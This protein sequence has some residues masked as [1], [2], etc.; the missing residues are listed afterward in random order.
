MSHAIQ[1]RIQNA[2]LETLPDP[3]LVALSLEAWEVVCQENARDLDLVNESQAEQ[4]IKFRDETNES[5]RSVLADFYEYNE[6]L[7][8]EK[9]ESLLSLLHKISGARHEAMERKPEPPQKP[10]E[11]LEERQERYEGIEKKHGFFSRFKKILGK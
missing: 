7:P 4:W 9:R 6:S 3:D 1:E 8:A 10:K 2:D 11:T 5:I